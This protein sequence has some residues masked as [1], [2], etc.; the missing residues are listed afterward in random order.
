METRLR[1]ANHRPCGRLLAC[2]ASADAYHYDLPIKTSIPQT[3]ATPHN[4]SGGF[5]RIFCPNRASRQSTKHK[6]PFPAS[7]KFRLCLGFSSPHK[8]LRPLWGPPE[9]KIHTVFPHFPH[10]RLEQNLL[11]K[12]LVP[13]CGIAL[14][15]META[16]SSDDANPIKL[17][18][19]IGFSM[20]S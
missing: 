10:F 19:F 15:I 16:A 13:L 4:G 2:I 12:I 6:A 7:G 5:R 20:R 9:W 1:L 3:K 14:K 8:G 11:P 18:D 17:N